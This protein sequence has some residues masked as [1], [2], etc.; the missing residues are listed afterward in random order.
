MKSFFILS[1]AACGLLLTLCRGQVF[2]QAQLPQ[3]RPAVSPYLNLQNRS[4]SAANNYYN[5]VRPQIDY[6]NAINKL[7]Q[8][9]TATQQNLSNFEAAEST[10]P[11]TGHAV[12]FQTHLKYFMNAGSSGGLSRSAGLPS[13]IRPP[14]PPQSSASQQAGGG[15]AAPPRSR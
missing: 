1:F 8:Q 10:L 4:G 5:L 9:S 11:A 7:Q 14:T 3:S 2:G 13:P 15:R 12:G 6:G